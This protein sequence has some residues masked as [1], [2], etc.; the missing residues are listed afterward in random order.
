M[1]YEMPKVV[2]IGP[3]CAAVQGTGKGSS[4]LEISHQPTNPAYEADE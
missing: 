1:K 4:N 2:P 3:A